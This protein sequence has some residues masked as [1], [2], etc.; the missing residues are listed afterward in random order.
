MKKLL[1]DICGIAFL[2]VLM[3]A[4]AQNPDGSPTIAYTIG[5]LCLAALLGWSFASLYKHEKEDD[6][7]K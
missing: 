6:D 1:T 5:L 2:L 4:C 7:E 3:C